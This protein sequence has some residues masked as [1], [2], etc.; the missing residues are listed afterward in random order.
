MR[1]WAYY[2]E[3]VEDWRVDVFSNEVCCAVTV[4]HVPTGISEMCNDY[5]SLMQNRAEAFKRAEA[6]IQT[7]SGLDEFHPDT[8]HNPE[9]PSSKRRR[10]DD[11][12]RP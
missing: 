6:R 7:P 3:R 2:P 4:T 1:D 12:T 5:S 10:S 11:R 9:K 8:T